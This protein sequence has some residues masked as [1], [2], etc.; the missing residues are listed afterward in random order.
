[1]DAREKYLTAFAAIAEKIN[2]KELAGPSSLFTLTVQQM[3]KDAARWLDDRWV[4]PTGDTADLDRVVQV[5]TQD[6]I[7]LLN[8]GAEESIQ[9]NTL[10]ELLQLA[11][12]AAQDEVIIDSTQ[13]RTI[14]QLLE[15]EA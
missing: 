1:M 12:Q 11:G 5:L 3:A 14:V 4:T 8:H 7:V 2:A 10:E 15:T 13:N 6:L 9:D